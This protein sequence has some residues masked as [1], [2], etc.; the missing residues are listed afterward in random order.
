MLQSYSHLG[1]SSVALVFVLPHFV[2][3]DS[4]LALAVVL[5]CTC[6]DGLALE[7]VL[8]IARGLFESIAFDEVECR[9]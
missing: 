5:E 8:A 3:V 9:L 1:F 2:K 4:Q 6:E 7:F